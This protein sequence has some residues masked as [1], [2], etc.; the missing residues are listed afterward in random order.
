MTPMPRPARNRARGSWRFA[1]GD[2]WFVACALAV[3]IASDY[4]FRVRSA[5]LTFQNSIDAGIIVEIGLYGLVGVYLF[6]SHPPRF[7]IRRMSMPM[8]AART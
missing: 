8:L 1:R 6:L 2:R 3:L 4:K 7:R 5:D